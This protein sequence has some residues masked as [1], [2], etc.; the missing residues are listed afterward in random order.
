MKNNTINYYHW[1]DIYKGLGIV[2]VVLGHVFYDNYIGQWIYSFHMPMFFILSGY[3]SYGKPWGGVN[4]LK[5]LLVPFVEFRIILVV[6]WYVIESRFR[7]LDLGPIWFLICLFFVYEITFPLCSFIKNKYYLFA[8]FVLYIV[9]FYLGKT[10]H[11]YNC[12]LVWLNSSVWII[13]GM[14]Y[15]FIISEKLF[16]N[17]FKR[18]KLSILV[19]LFVSFLAPIINGRVSIYSNETNNFILY[20]VLGLIGS[21]LIYNISFYIICEN[22][23]IEY[24]GKYSII[25]LAFHEPIK[26]IIIYVSQQIFGLFDIFI[27]KVYFND[28]YYAGLI[29][30]I[31]V[32]LFCIPVIESFRK[33]KYKY[34]IFN[35]ILPYIK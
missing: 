11:I 12:I 1:V 34:K 6:Y 16:K 29:L 10:L 13:I 2:F 33:L 30:S 7:E 27:N 8:W 31:L 5:S 24:V 22:R 20:L 17:C 23:F 18:N 14:I 25:I 21:Y 32:L 15:K 9:F 35:L 3:L 28:N 4:K 19:L 26:R